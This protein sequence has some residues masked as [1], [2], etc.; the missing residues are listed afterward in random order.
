MLLTSISFPA[1]PSTGHIV[2]LS[3]LLANV[4]IVV[5][6]LIQ[7]DHPA[8]RGILSHSQG[9]LQGPEGGMYFT[10]P[11]CWQVTQNNRRCPERASSHSLSAANTPQHDMSWTVGVLRTI[12]S[13]SRR[14]QCLFLFWDTEGG[15]KGGV[16]ISL[17]WIKNKSRDFR[18]YRMRLNSKLKRRTPCRRHRITTS[19]WHKQDSHICQV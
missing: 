13:A 7:S 17:L 4:S 12:P 14:A 2:S 3:E 18:N 11:L 16:Q 9:L 1:C 15:R 8:G 10:I 19:E 6:T 5:V